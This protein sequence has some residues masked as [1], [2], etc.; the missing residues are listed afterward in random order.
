[1]EIHPAGLILLLPIIIIVYAIR[2]AKLLIFI[3]LGWMKSRRSLNMSPDSELESIGWKYTVYALN[4][5]KK[6]NTKKLR[7]DRGAQLF[8]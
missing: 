2:A 6:N 7:P 1:M 3:T 5:K 8:L 4:A